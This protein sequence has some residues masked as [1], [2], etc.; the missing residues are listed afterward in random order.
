MAFFFMI[1]I[2][3][4]YKGNRVVHNNFTKLLRKFMINK[5]TING[6]IRLFNFIIE[7]RNFIV[8]IT[9]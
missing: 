1:D 4:I 9:T 8:F 3:L 7:I 2:F 6:I 5:Q